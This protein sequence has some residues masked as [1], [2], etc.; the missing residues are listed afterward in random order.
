[1]IQASTDG[2][3]ALRSELSMIASDMKKEMRIAAKN[4][5]TK[6]RTEIARGLGKVVRVKQKWLKKVTVTD[7]DGDSVTLR[8]RGRFRVALKWFNPRQTAAGIVVKTHKMPVEADSRRPYERGFMGTRPG[9]YSTKLRG[10]AVYRVGDRRKPIRAVR[11]VSPVEDIKQHRAVLDGAIRDV[12]GLMQQEIRRRIRY[13]KLK[14]AGG[15]RGRQT[16]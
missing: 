13:L 14:A 7:I 2:L 16:R 10:Q 9:L 6:G 5:G 15:L 11:A 8:M 4:A 1:M 12:S 3:R